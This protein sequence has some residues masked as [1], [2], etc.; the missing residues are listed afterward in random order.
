[1]LGGE[2]HESDAEDGV[3]AGGEDADFLL[4][5]AVLFDAE[6]DLGALAAADPVG[7]HGVDTV[8]PLDAAEVEEFVGIFCDSEEPLLEVSAGDGCGAAFAGA[9]GEDLFVGEGGLAGRAPVGGGLV[10][11]GEAGVEELQEEPLGPLVV[12]GEGGDDFTV[13]VV[14]SADALELAAHVF[15]VAHGPDVGVDAVLDGGVLG[16]EAEGVEAHRVEDVVALH[17]P[18]AGVDV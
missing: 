4:V 7:L 5:E 10:A 12:V 1:M 6:G 16:G 14:D 3:G 8:G 17:A 9:V 13:P 2:D 18:E 11:V 15:D